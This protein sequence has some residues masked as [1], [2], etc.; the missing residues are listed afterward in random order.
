MLGKSFRSLPTM[1]L[2]RSNA[3]KLAGLVLAVAL[4]GCGGSGSGTPA[5]MRVAGDGFGFQAPAGWQIKRT[6]RSVEAH[7][8]AAIVSVTTFTLVRR[9]RPA[10]WPSVVPEL[11]RVAQQL[12]GRVHGKVES[13]KTATIAARKARVYA[14]SRGGEDETIAF[15][16]NARREYQLYC[17]GA[18]KACDTLLATFRLAA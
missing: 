14:I 5:G 1:V 9:Y 8:G 18:G 3:R 7:R 13:S 17:R 10:L 6:L 12:A 15:V 2:P 16:L 11:D 4:A